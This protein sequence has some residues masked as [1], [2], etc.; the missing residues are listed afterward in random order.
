[1]AERGWGRIVNVCSSAAKRPS[2]GTPEYSV[3]K[4]AELSLSRLFADRYAKRG[5][6]VNAVCP[7]PVAS[8]LWM[9]AGGLLAQARER[10]GHGSRGGAPGAGGAGRPAGGVAPARGSAPAGRL[11]P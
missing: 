2:G 3:A 6:L 7:G 8:E 9:E 10:G 5:V 1:M 4:A 11:L